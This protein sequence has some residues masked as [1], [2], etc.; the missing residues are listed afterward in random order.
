MLKISAIGCY[1]NVPVDIKGVGTGMFGDMQC[2]GLS[3]KS[4]IVMAVAGTFISIISGVGSGK[5]DSKFISAGPECWYNPFGAIV[6]R[7]R[8]IQSLYPERDLHRKARHGN[9][10]QWVFLQHQRYAWRNL[11]VN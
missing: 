10:I 3:M 9:S 4:G 11:L 6:T 1:A 8:H 7:N 2:A 5:T